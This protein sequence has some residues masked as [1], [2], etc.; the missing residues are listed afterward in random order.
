MGH[1]RVM[2]HGVGDLKKHH[3][4]SH[5]SDVSR[6]G[7]SE[8][9]PL[10]V[11]CEWCV[12]AREI[13]RNT[14]TGHMRVMC[15]GVGDLKKHHY[16]SHAS[17]LSWRGRSEETP[18]WVTCEWCVM[19][20]EIWRNTIMGHMRVMFHGVGDLKKHHYGSHA[21]DLLSWIYNDK[22][23]QFGYDLSSAN[24]VD[25]SIHSSLVTLSYSH[26]P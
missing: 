3:Y 22:K 18:L 24:L 2:C 19:A 13:W 25:C 6:R 5:A 4:G 12:T 20:W 26:N 8:E 17:D 15:H 21:S 23:D 16:G 1:M 9:T 10:R 7:R 11:T 14:I